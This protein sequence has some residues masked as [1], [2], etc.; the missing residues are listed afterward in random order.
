M[1]T[2]ETPQ[3]SSEETKIELNRE[4][5]VSLLETGGWA[6][7]LAIM[8]FI[9]IGFMVL[10]AFSIGSFVPKTLDDGSPFPFPVGLFS[11]IYVLIA[12]VYFF[13]VYYLFNFANQVRNGIRF[14]DANKVASA[15]RSL[16]SHYKFV[17]IITICMIVLYI[18]IILL[19]VALGAG[20]MMGNSVNA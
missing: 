9:F 4:S 8:G 11:F 6:N 1:D 14:R 2:L 7:F 5:L 20:K 12:L 10:I 16:K 15:M 17:G 18:L 13:P 3:N 19:V